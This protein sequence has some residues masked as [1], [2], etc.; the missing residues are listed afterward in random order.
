[1][2]DRTGET[3]SLESTPKRRT[4]GAIEEDQRKAKEVFAKQQIEND[5]YHAKRNRAKVKREK[6][7][8]RHK[9]EN[10]G[11]PFDLDGD[12]PIPPPDSPVGRAFHKQHYVL[13]AI[14]K[15]LEAAKRDNN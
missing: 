10:P 13:D 7:H 5:E 3:M 11:E 14:D 8:D 12:Y 2:A 4:I 15:E 1:M 9:L 6:A